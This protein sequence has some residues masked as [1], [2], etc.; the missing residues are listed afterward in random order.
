[1]IK[2]ADLKRTLEQDGFTDVTTYIQS[3]NVFFNAD[4][5]DK[6]RLALSVSKCI[7]EHFQ[8]E[9]AAAVF[10]KDN[11]QKII[12]AAPLWWGKDRAW[13]HNLLVLLEPYDMNDV[14]KAIGELK[15]DVES[16]APGQGV[17]YQSMSLKLFGRTT[18]G[19]LAS[20]PIYKKMTVRNYNTA[21]KLA[22]LF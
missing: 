5:K 11:W 17:L 8:L 9:V 22:T 13:K 6:T 16:M 20:S 7:K 4:E 18:T 12:K 3:G 14:V 2:M 1:M 21:T 19:K 10:T 15:P